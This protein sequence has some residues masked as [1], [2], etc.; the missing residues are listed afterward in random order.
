M[1]RLDYVILQWLPNDYRIK[2]TLL[3][4]HAELSP[5]CPALS[6]TLLCVH[7]LSVPQPLSKIYGLKSIILQCFQRFQILEASLPLDVIEWIS[8]NDVS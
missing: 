6:T 8:G 7:V 5:V 2:F 4:Q 1:H 3:S